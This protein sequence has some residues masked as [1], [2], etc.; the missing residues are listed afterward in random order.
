MGRDDDRSTSRPSRV[1]ALLHR[2]SRRAFL[3][4]TTLFVGAVAPSRFPVSSRPTVPVPTGGAGPLRFSVRATWAIPR[5][6]AFVESERPKKGDRRPSELAGL[7][8]VGQTSAQHPCSFC[9]RSIV[10]RFGLRCVC[11]LLCRLRRWCWW[12]EYYFDPPLTIAAGLL[13]TIN[14]YTHGF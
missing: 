8:S 3:A 6:H 5:P 1:P 4:C 10:F 13:S 7:G 12:F 14:E 9:R 11:G 2:P